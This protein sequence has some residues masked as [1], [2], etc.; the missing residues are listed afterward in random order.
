LF[1][2]ACKI[3]KHSA[4]SIRQSVEATQPPLGDC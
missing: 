4:I 1:S 2:F 3:K